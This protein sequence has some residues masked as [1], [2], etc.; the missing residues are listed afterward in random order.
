MIDAP[1]DWPF[2][3]APN[4]T[5]ITTVSVLD[6]DFPIL[7]VTH[8][9]DDQSWAFVCGTANEVADGRVIGMD[10]ALSI[11]PTFRTIADL[12][13]GWTAWRERVGDEWQRDPDDDA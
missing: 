11:D 12:P 10:C 13:R 8:Y 4:V 3:Q 2:D 1:T 9:S 7:R 6:D 5:A